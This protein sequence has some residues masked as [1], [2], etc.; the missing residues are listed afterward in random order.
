MRFSGSC[1][2]IFDSKGRTEIGL[3][4]DISD[5]SP[6]LK[7][8]VTLAFLKISGNSPVVMLKLMIFM[9]GGAI[10]AEPIFRFGTQSIKSCRFDGSRALSCF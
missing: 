7:H 3:Y 8:G 6:F 5:L 9:R 4:L 1:F 10:A 2:S